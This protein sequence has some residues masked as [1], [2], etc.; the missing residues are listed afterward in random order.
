M[1]TKDV[2]KI[3]PITSPKVTAHQIPSLPINNG[4]KYKN[5]IWKINVL[6]NEIIKDNKPLFKA[7][8]KD[9]KKIEN[10]QAK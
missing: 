6:A 5:P 3:A 10:P 8:K 2:D 9:E 7:V 1:I 4:I